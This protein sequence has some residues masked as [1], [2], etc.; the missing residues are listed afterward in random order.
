[1][2]IITAQQNVTGQNTATH[3]AGL[4]CAGSPI[5]QRMKKNLIL[6]KKSSETFSFGERMD[7]VDTCTVWMKPVCN[8]DTQLAA[9]LSG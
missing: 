2:I 9:W 7:T 1:V 5:R 6:V 4:Q 8:N 3:S